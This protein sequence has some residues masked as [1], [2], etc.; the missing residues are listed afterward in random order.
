MRE[1]MAAAMQRLASDRKLVE[2][3]GVAARKFSLGFTWENA[4]AQTADHLREVVMAR[5]DRNAGN[6]R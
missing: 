3:L 2:T 1:A 4:A 5:A 6:I